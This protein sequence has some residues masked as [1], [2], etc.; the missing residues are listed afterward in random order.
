MHGLEAMGRYVCSLQPNTSHHWQFQGGTRLSSFVGVW[1]QNLH[2]VLRWAQL[3]WYPWSLQTNSLRKTELRRALEISSSFVTCPNSHF[4]NKGWITKA[5]NFGSYAPVQI[6]SCLALIKLLFNPSL[7]FN[8]HRTICT[9]HG[10][11]ILFGC[12]CQWKGRIPTL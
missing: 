8:L 12:G 10:I 4:H 11:M 6:G 5:P 3:Y 9:V 1:S 2:F 7:E